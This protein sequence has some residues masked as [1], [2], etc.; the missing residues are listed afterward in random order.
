MRI[1]ATIQN[2]Q[3]LRVTDWCH[4]AQVVH[5]ELAL[6]APTFSHHLGATQRRH[7]TPA[8]AMSLTYAGGVGRGRTVRP[9][10]G[11]ICNTMKNMYNYLLIIYN[12][13]NYE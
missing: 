9:E 3:I 10:I 1:E 7:R 6:A 11:S 13:A 5:S 2:K 8:V 4:T 12:D